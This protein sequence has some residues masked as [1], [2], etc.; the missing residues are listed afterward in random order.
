MIYF[1]MDEENF[2]FLASEVGQNKRISLILLLN[3]FTMAEEY[4]KFRSSE[5]SQNES[6]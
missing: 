3:S 5:I 2:E 4:F 6:I 1:T